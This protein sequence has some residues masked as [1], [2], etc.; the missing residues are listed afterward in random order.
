MMHLCWPAWAALYPFFSL[1]GCEITG[2]GVIGLPLQEGGGSSG[3][4]AQ[5]E[6]KLWLFRDTLCVADYCSEGGNP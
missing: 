1:S 6:H 4:G 3:A 2:V 5:I